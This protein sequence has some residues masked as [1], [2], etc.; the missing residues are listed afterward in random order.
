MSFERKRSLYNQLCLFDLPWEPVSRMAKDDSA[1]K[2]RIPPLKIE[3]LNQHQREVLG[4]GVT[5]GLKPPAVN[6]L[7]RTVIRHDQAF[8]VW[9]TLAQFVNNSSRLP[10]RDRE[11]MIHRLCWLMKAEW[12]WG[13]HRSR[14]LEAGLTLDEIERVK[15]G[16]DAT[17]WTSW[18]R[19][20]LRAVD[21][22]HL[23]AKIPD[24]VWEELSQTYDEKQ[25]IELVLHTGHYQIANMMT[26]ALGIANEPGLPTF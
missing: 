2:T 6:Q 12:E 23:Q 5:S 14:A 15:S 18:D 3:E 21:A 1:K 26:N 17:E 13:K 20:L 10:A 4:I 22:L 24:D 16:P 25:M 11:L 19:T 8:A 9:R 7:F